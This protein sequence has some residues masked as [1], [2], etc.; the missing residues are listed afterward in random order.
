VKLTG[1]A[2]RRSPAARAALE[3]WADA[4]IRVA[5]LDDYAADPSMT[6]DGLL[7]LTGEPDDWQR[8]WR[9]LAE[10][11]ADYDLV[12]DASCGAEL[13][14][15]TGSRTLAPYCEP[16]RSRAW[17]MSAGAD[18]VRIILPGAEPSSVR[19]TDLS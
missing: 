7:V 11:R 19:R 8:H 17:L 14:L 4:G 5:T 6:A 12:V 15:L 18:P 9:V 2:A 13:R 10:V 1:F 3:A 16:G